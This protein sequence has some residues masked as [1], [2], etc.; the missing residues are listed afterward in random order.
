VGV[1]HVQVQEDK[2]L[3]FGGLTIRA[4]ARE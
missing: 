2:E 1:H 3:T 4:L